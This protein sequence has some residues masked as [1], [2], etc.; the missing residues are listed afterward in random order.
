MKKPPDKPYS[1][2]G[3]RTGRVLHVSSRMRQAQLNLDEGRP[4]VAGVLFLGGRISPIPWEWFYEE[5]P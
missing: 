2:T 3:M 1:T 5:T 4:A